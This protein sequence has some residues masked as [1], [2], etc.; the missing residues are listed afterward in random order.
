MSASQNPTAPSAAHVF[1]PPPPP[2]PPPPALLTGAIAVTIDQFY[3]LGSLN[4]NIQFTMT[5]TINVP[6]PEP[7]M[8]WLKMSFQTP[9]IITVTPMNF[10]GNVQLT[11]TLVD[12]DH[13]LIGVGF[14]AIDTALTGAGVSTFPTI[15]FDRAMVGSSWQTDMIVLDTLAAGVAT[16]YS[17][18]IIVQEVSSQ[19]LG[20]IDPVI[21]NE[22]G[23]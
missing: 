4:G 12:P 8:P 7:G 16:T 13:L 23:N 18:F 2:P 10:S 11:Y 22:P 20:I 6:P 17:Y 15:S 14:N 3:P 5:P 1:P 9:N 19:T 21:V